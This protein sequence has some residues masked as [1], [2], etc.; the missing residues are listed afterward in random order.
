MK[1]PGIDSPSS[2]NILP[3]LSNQVF[4]FN[5]DS[6]PRGTPRSIE[7]A[8]AARPSFSELGKRSK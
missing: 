1:K 6:I 5:A 2:A 7:I 8:K 4:G 3:K